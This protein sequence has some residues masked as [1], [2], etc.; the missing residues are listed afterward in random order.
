VAKAES[1]AAEVGG[2]KQVTDKIQVEANNGK[3]GRRH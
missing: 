3:S 1:L 2:V